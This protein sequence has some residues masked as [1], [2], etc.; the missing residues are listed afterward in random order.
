MAKDIVQQSPFDSIRKVDAAGVESWSAR[1]LMKLLGYKQW[2]RF[3]DS[4]D[5]AIMSCQ[6]ADVNSSQHFLHLP[7][8]ANG[9]GQGKTGADY[10]LTRY[11]CYLVAMNGDV[12]K[13]EIALAQ[14]YF[15]IKAREAE[16]SQKAPAKILNRNY[17]SSQKECR[18]QLKRHGAGRKAY[19][20]TEQYNN[21]L[22][23]VESGRRHEVTAEQANQLN[24]NYL[25]GAIELLKREQGFNNCNDY[26]LANTTKMAMRHGMY[27]QL[28]ADSVPENLKPFKERRL[29]K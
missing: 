10:T 13:P 7:E 6:S 4:I 12:R 26:H 29:L 1:D 5:R 14:S 28:G 25:M 24:C 8:S 18:D 2:R 17:A 23:G 21:Q 15:A 9:R 16:L 22:S 19:Q 11:A 3:E 20:L 27:E